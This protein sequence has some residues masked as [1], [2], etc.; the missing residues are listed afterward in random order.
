[1]QPDAAAP[2]TSWLLDCY[3]HPD[4]RAETGR[5]LG[6]VPWPAGK[7]VIAY[8]GPPDGYRARS[9]SPRCIKCPAAL[10]ETI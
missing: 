10:S 5:L 3:V 7:A 1:M 8:S 4:F 6:A 9:T 2:G